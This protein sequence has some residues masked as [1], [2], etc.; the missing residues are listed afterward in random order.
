MINIV[1]LLG[2]EHRAV[3]HLTGITSNL[4]DAV[5]TGHGEVIVRSLGVIGSFLAGS[6]LSGFLIQDGTLKL[7]RSYGLSLG[8]EA[9]LLFAAV[10]LLERQFHL[11][12]CLAAAAC[13][14]Q[15]AMAT[16]YSGA[17]VRTTHLSGMFTDLGIFL[18]HRCRG[19]AVDL[20]RIKLCLVIISGFFCGGVAGGVAFRKMGYGTLYLPATGTG[21]AAIIY[22]AQSSW[23]RG[24]KKG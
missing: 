6:M 9:M 21:L 13:G 7:G 5:A 15:N 22:T 1:G 16:T 4:S 20:R 11:G 14:L 17:S 2:F 23:T 12:V 24:S 10:P 18:G 8:L 19:L 3:T